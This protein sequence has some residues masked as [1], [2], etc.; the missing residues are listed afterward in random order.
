MDIG[1]ESVE[2]PR[3]KPPAHFSIDD[4]GMRF[5]GT[6]PDLE[7]VRGFAPYKEGQE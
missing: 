2:F 5:E 7:V 1:L 4:R 3:R 6:F